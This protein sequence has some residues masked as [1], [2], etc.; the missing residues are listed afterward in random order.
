MNTR[1]LSL[2]QFGRAFAQGTTS[3]IHIVNE[4]NVAVFEGSG[5]SESSPHILKALGVRETHLR[6][7]RLCSPQYV[8]Q[9]SSPILV[10][11][12]KS[13]GDFHGLI[14]SPLLQPPRMEGNGN[15]GV[16]PHGRKGGVLSKKPPQN[17]AQGQHI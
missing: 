8:G 3:G 1:G 17:M 14:I 16:K 7:G 2:V 5:D 10:E 15:N 12:K 11:G 4:Q 13:S 9:D 6:A